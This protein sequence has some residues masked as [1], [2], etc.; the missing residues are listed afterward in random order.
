LIYNSSGYVLVY[1]QLIHFTKN[2][3]HSAIEKKEIHE[4]IILLSFKKSDIEQGKVNLKWKDKKEFR[5]NEGMYDIVEKI[6]S[7][8]SIYFFCFFDNK[9]NLLEANFNK[10]FEKEKEDKKRNSSGRN[11][12][13]QQTTDQYF[14]TEDFFSYQQSELTYSLYLEKGNS[15]N[16]PDV[17]SPPPKL[18]YSI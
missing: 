16:E 18:F 3:I 1:Q 9:E 11:L 10:H 7:E 5:Y 17:P 6:E 8:D 2:Y 14:I 13:T 4:K 12:L 15:L